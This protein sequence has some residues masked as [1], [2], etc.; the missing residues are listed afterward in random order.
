MCCDIAFLRPTRH[1]TLSCSS[2]AV[3]NISKYLEVA[4]QIFQTVPSD[5]RP[6]N[7]VVATLTMHPRYLSK[8]DYPTDLFQEVGIRAI[9]SKVQRVQPKKWGID[10]AGDALTETYYVAGELTAFEQWSDAL[11]QWDARASAAGV[12]LHIEDLAAFRAEDKLK[13]LPTEEGESVYEFV[14]H[15]AHDPGIVEAFYSYARQHQGE[16]IEDKRRDVRGLTFLPVRTELAS[17]QALAEFTFVRV[18]RGMPALRPFQPVM[19]RSA[20][21]F[22]VNLPDVDALDASVKTVIFDGGLPT[23][24]P[25]ERWVNYIE[26]AGIGPSVPG[27]LDHGLAVT[28]ALLFGSLVKGQNPLQPFSS[29]DHV[30]V[31]DDQSGVNDLEIIDVLD[32]IKNHLDTHEYQFANMSL[33]PDLA[34]ED[35]EVTLWTAALDERFANGAIVTTVAVGNN[36]M[37]D[38]AS[39][40][41]RVQV[42]SDAVNV[43]SVGAADSLGDHWKRASYSAVGPGRSPGRAKPDLVAF[44]GSPS[45]P[46]MVLSGDGQG[47]ATEQWGTSFAAPLALRST[48]AVRAILGPDVSCLAL[49]AL[50]IHRADPSTHAMRDVGWG[51]L[52]M[53]PMDLVTTADDEAIVLY[54]GDLLVGQ[55]MRVPIPLSGV[56]LAGSVTLTATLLIAPEVDPE[57][58]GAYTRS[59]VGVSFRPN[60]TR[61]RRTNGKLSSHPV[62]TSFFKNRRFLVARNMRPE[63]MATSGNQRS[64]TAK[65]LKRRPW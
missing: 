63:K 55:H 10:K 64:G 45:E 8:S 22:A 38:A 25:L 60:F 33:G 13:S 49:R 56:N 35:D 52:E 51:R 30:R 1:S 48:V 15:N 44:G 11:K 6:N 57:F 61:Y 17:V 5:A 39:G 46:F 42:P 3:T 26:P 2:A 31:L 59:G 62:T 24:N 50:M 20:L 28:S 29:V 47:R 19:L 21:G 4:E 32:R 65:I 23:P 53:D 7:Q 34:V 9:G 40:M 54:Q 41:N 16:P 58:P 27:C 14:L 37:E 43:L 18:A 12:L 36:G